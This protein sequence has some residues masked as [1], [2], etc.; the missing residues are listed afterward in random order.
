MGYSEE[1]ERER[2]KKRQLLNLAFCFREQGKHVHVLPHANFSLRAIVSVSVSKHGDVLSQLHFSRAQR[3]IS[4]VAIAA[5]DFASV[6][7]YR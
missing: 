6:S 7:F 5:L 1:I 4:L 3:N 2:G